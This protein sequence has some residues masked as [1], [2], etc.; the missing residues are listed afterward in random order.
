MKTLII[1]ENDM[2][3]RNFVSS[4]ALKEQ[5]ADP[6]TM[7]VLSD[8]PNKLVHLIPKEKLLGRYQ[9]SPYAT[10]MVY[11]INR[12]SMLVFRHLSSTLWTKSEFNWLAPPYDSRERRVARELYDKGHSVEEYRQSMKTALPECLANPTLKELLMDYRPDVVLCPFTG[13][14]A[15]GYHLIHYGKL[16]GFKVVWL[17]NGIDNSSSKGI[18]PMIP[19]LT[20]CLSECQKQEMVKI[21]G[22]PKDKLAVV[23][24]ARYEPLCYGGSCVGAPLVLQV[25]RPYLLFVGTCAPV[26][27]VAILR[28][29]DAVAMNYG[30][31]VIYRP[32]PWRERREVE[33]QFDKTEFGVT[34][35]DPQYTDE[36]GAKGVSSEAY[37]DL[38]YYVGLLSCA[39][40]LVAT[41]T[42]M[43][44][45]G[46]LFDLPVMVLGHDDDP[47][48]ITP[49]M[50]LEYEHFKQVEQLSGVRAVRGGD[51]EDGIFLAEHDGWFTGLTTSLPDPEYSMADMQTKGFLTTKPGTYSTRLQYSVLSMGV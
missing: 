6:N 42:S 47:H 14:E 11:N 44:L 13:V 9:R 34:K 31:N 32:H 46:R 28:E 7:V 51:L 22:F 24:C 30:L 25:S 18:F 43:I 50:Q 12:W 39:S 19:D 15:L 48:P 27:D 41:P 1:I 33:G 10:Q 49:G 16:L 3:L 36:W 2:Y 23:G 29:L 35:L 8:Q 21:Q 4:G 38:N 40:G 37:P 45:E 20:V 26:D 17:L 5:L